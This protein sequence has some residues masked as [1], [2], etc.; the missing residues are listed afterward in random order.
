MN[1]IWHLARKDLRRLRIPGAIFLVLLVCKL[2]LGL[3]ILDVVDQHQ[4]A[5]LRD[6][7]KVALMA[8]TIFGYVLVAAII[9]ED[10]L[11]GS[12][13]FWM[14]RPISGLQLLAAKLL[15]LLLIVV[16]L[17][18]LVML[19]W[20]LACDLNPR[21][22]LAAVSGT[23]F[24]QTLIVLAG[25]PFAV[26]TSNLARYIACTAGVFATLFAAK[27]LLQRAGWATPAMLP[28]AIESRSTA[29][30]LIMCATVLLV[31]IHQ[32]RTRR[33]FRSA[34]IVATGL[35]LAFAANIAWPSGWSLL[36][37]SSTAGIDSTTVRID[38]EAANLRAHRDTH[39][40]GFLTLRGRIHGLPDNAVPEH[41][42]GRQIWTW[43]DGT[44]TTLP[45]NKPSASTAFERSV[46]KH[47]GLSVN[48]SPRSS[49]RSYGEVDADGT[50]LF[51]FS[52]SL[53]GSA[54]GKAANP[55]RSFALDAHTRLL[56]PAL[57][58][59]TDLAVGAS[60]AS[61]GR[62]LRVLQITDTSPDR[63]EISL[64]EITPPSRAPALHTHQLFLIDRSIDLLSGFHEHRSEHFIVSGVTVSARTFIGHSAQLP[65]TL[66]PFARHRHTFRLAWVDYKSLGSLTLSTQRSDLPLTID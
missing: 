34:A 3:Q 47:L 4:F 54:L 26:L 49:L 64:L 57:I 52:A 45:I 55:P 30:T 17:P 43:A 56:E 50:R 12:R 27:L 48:T 1:L 10:P 58:G 24:I 6:H 44:Q 53:P 18:A 61:S 19:P 5:T 28:D 25:L 13:A 35:S 29:I 46:R 2:L 14:T 40:D 31:V 42:T 11:V 38:V 32:Y 51:V 62:T 39:A 63:T 21:G 15:V 9:Q 66:T 60:I 20:W 7:L 22:L 36:R 59:E 65:E 8:E 16:L 41:F 33:T 23:L 37:K